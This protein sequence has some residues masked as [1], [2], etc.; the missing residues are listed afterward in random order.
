[1]ILMQWLIYLWDEIVQIQDPD[2]VDWPWR[3]WQCH[4]RYRYA[5]TYRRSRR[6]RSHR[7]RVPYFWRETDATFR[8]RDRAQSHHDIRRP[9]SAGRVRSIRRSSCSRNSVI[10]RRACAARNDRFCRPRNNIGEPDRPCRT[11]VIDRQTHVD[12]SCLI[13]KMT[14]FK[15]KIIFLLIL[16]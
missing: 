16:I 2:W 10:G 5:Q 4:R 13:K 11:W 8:P 15:V 14:R 12:K 6:V 3:P 9:P 1:M 7:W